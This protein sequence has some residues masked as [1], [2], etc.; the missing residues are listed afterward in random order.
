MTIVATTIVHPNP[1]VASDDVQK[2]L[3][4]ASELACKHGAENTWISKLK[5]GRSIRFG[6]EPS[7]CAGSSTRACTGTKAEGFQPSSQT[8]P[9]AGRIECREGGRVVL[10]SVPPANRR[11]R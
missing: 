5:R 8:D 11:T 1:G 3:K 9:V 6:T 2:H 7:K 4:R 10:G